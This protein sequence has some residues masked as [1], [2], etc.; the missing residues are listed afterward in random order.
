MTG[1]V[2]PECD[3]EDDIAQDARELQDA[4]RAI[5]L[6][7]AAAATPAQRTKRARA[8]GKA[9]AKAL[10]PKQRRERAS[11]AGVARWAK[12]RGTMRI[13]SG[14]KTSTFDGDQIATASQVARFVVLDDIR[15]LSL[16]ARTNSV[17]SKDGPLN[18]LVDVAPT[19]S[20]GSD[21]ALIA[22][23]P[24]KV[25]LVD[26]AFPDAIR[27]TVDVEYQLRYHMTVPAP[28]EEHRD[29]LLSAFSQINSV[30]NAW[31]FLRETIHSLSGRLGLQTPVLPVLRISATP[32]APPHIEASPHDANQ[33]LA[34]QANP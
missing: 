8:G 11:K 4:A 32:K 2:C 27:A 33:D 29:R 15:A 6:A 16:M 5:G 26:S 7:S 21:G 18:I 1:K 3:H 31:P 17:S 19:Y 23:L 14:E 24:F 13:L 12:S 22:T 10:T 20:I 30:F 34:A 25:L 9:S 28:P